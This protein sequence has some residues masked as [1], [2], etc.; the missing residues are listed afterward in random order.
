MVATASASQPPPK[1]AAPKPSR[2]MRLFSNENKRYISMTGQGA[3]CQSPDVAKSALHTAA[4]FR[5]S[6]SRKTPAT[7]HMLKY[8][9]GGGGGG[10]RGAEGYRS[11]VRGPEPPSRKAVSTPRL[12]RATSEERG[13]RG[14]S[15]RRNSRRRVQLKYGGK[16]SSGR[17]YI[18]GLIFAR[19]HV[20]LTPRRP[21]SIVA[22]SPRTCT[23]PHITLSIFLRRSGAARCQALPQLALHISSKTFALSHSGGGD[24][25]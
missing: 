13:A 10:G 6:I 24:G 23:K 8:G 16:S 14:Q 9:R 22:H 20:V 21:I 2:F 5:S 18:A 4:S 1:I 17:V 25:N 15:R 11:T 7:A 12:Q 3:V 19:K